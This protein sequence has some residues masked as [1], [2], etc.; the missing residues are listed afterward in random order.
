MR[1]A[2]PWTH[3]PWQEPE[4][5]VPPASL[6]FS[7]PC[8]G[9]EAGQALSISKHLH[10]ELFS[11]HNG[12]ILPALPRRRHLH[13]RGVTW[14]LFPASGSPG[15]GLGREVTAFL[16]AFNVVLQ[17]KKIYIQVLPKWLP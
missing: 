14:N 6:C 10:L 12:H 1:R 3:S 15:C 2:Q 7:R 9:L 16:Q 17:A 5:R 8:V 4:L 13:H 11:L